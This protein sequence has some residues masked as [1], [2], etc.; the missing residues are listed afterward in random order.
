MGDATRILVID[1]DPKIRTV[2]RRGLAYEGYRVVEAASGEEG[3]RRRES[4][5]PTSSS[6]TSCCPG[7]MAWRSAAGS[8]RRGTSWGS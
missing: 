8:G 4:T 7:S 6:S 3:L 2:V 5:S 1:D